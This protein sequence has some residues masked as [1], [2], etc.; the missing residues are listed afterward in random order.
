[1]LNAT[2]MGGI[3]DRNAE[4]DVIWDFATAITIT[5]ISKHE[6]ASFCEHLVNMPI[7]RFHC[8]KH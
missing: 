8:V 5:N 4:P 3:L 2:F 6:R 1:M 7:R